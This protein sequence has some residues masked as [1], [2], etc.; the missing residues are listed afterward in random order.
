MHPHPGFIKLCGLARA[1]DVEA[2]AAAEPNALGFIF[3]PKSPRAVS[4]ADVAAWTRGL[5]S[6]LRKVGVFVNPDRDELLSTAEEAGLDVL[7]LHGQEDA[8]FLQ[9]V[10]LPAWKALH[11][12]R[13][14]ADWRQLP[15]DRFLIDSGTVEMPGGTGQRV[16]EGRAID[17]ITASPHPVLLA[18]GL[19]ADNVRDAILA[20]RP[21]GVDVSSGVE[22]VPG[23]KDHQAL[24]RFVQEARQAFMEQQQ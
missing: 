5:P 16:D 1:A 21:W 13:L 8:A 19:N 10:P 11:A 14:P 12:D 15:V 4:P 2:A 9:D 20:T 22:T 7:Q 3:W 6:H 17:L 24:Q 23:V 18:G